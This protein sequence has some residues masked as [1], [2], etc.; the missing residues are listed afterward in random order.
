ME[1]PQLRMFVVYTQFEG[2]LYFALVPAALSDERMQAALH[3]LGID[4]DAVFELDGWRR[5]DDDVAVA[6]VPFPNRN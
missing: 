4:A 2:G 1:D 5:T 3:E 6:Y